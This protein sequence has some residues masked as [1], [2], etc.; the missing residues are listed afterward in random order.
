MVAND[1]PLTRREAKAI[2]RQRLLDAALQILDDEGE[3]GLSTTNITRRAGIAQSS[4]YVH[5]E[6][7]NEL[8]HE[9][10]DHLA[11]ER[12]RTT[13][14]ARRLA[15][16]AP[17]DR[18]RLRDT[19]RIPLLDLV[20][21]PHILRL[22]LRSRYEPSSPLGAWSR[23]IVESSEEQLVRDLV[24]AGAPYDTDEQR[25]RLDMY[26]EGVVALV[27]A[28]ALGH[29]EGRYPDVEEVVDML[30]AFARVTPRRTA[31]AP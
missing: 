16:S 8:L 22:L 14:K 17:G 20:A 24:A 5:F 28:F 31:T 4:F 18:E 9:L 21:H 13:R 7:V 3:S 15:G 10:V 11:Q 19:F 6:D 1:R 26:A 29:V 23:S 27:E 12:D 2:T 25:R 30:M